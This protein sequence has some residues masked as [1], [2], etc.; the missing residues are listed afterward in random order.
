MTSRKCSRCG[1]FDMKYHFDTKHC[2]DCERKRVSTTFRLSKY[3]IPGHFTTEQQEVCIDVF[4]KLKGW[5]DK[6]EGGLIQISG[7]GGCGKTE[8]LSFLT[9][10][11]HSVVCGPTHKSVQVLRDRLKSTDYANKVSIQTCHQFFNASPAY[12][13]AGELQFKVSLPS[14]VE[15]NV[16]LI[17]EV[18][19]IPDDIYEVYMKM[20]EKFKLYIIT[21]GDEA[22]L[23]PVRPNKP[24]APSLFYK[25]HSIDFKLKTNFRNEYPEY[26][27]I[28]NG[29]RIHQIENRKDR[30]PVLELLRGLEK[31][32]RK[33]AIDM[34]CDDDG[35]NRVIAHRTNDKN[36]TVSKLNTMVRQKL[37]GVN[38]NNRFN[39][40]ERVE[41]TDHHTGQLLVKEPP[42][43]ESRIRYYANDQV[44]IRYVNETSR[45]Y[46]GKDIRV[47]ELKLENGDTLYSVYTEDLLLFNR[48]VEKRKK[49]VLS[50]VNRVLIPLNDTEKYLLWQDFYDESSTM[51]A[52][53]DYSYAISCHKSQ[54]SSYDKVYVNIEDFI[55]F[56]KTNQKSK[57][58]QFLQLLYVALSRSRSTAIL[59]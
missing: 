37:Y 13:D 54:G 39:S 38:A 19:M 17:D 10:V 48:L 21:F 8:I 33:E 55:W 36:N 7:R 23:T 52:P 42:Y 44:I 5:K 6:K 4:K 46:E 29:L 59:F 24:L 16:L 3:L 56:F 45:S 34:F 51:N 22:Q 25:N 47:Y 15:C 41:F 9:G 35:D 30:F 50:Q 18:S 27:S 14:R 1:K 11:T 43:H 58:K 49:Y 26:N 12:T 40:G 31:V 20:I 28:L 53:I 2:I 57:V 32:S